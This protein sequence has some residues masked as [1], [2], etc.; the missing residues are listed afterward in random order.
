[1]VNFKLWVLNRLGY[2]MQALYLEPDSVVG[3]GPTMSNAILSNG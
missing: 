3:I 1:M 2:Y